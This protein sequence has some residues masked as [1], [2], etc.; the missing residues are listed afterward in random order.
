MNDSQKNTNLRINRVLAADVGST[1]PLAARQM[2]NEPRDADDEDD[3][4]HRPK[5]VVGMKIG[6]N[7]CKLYSTKN[8]RKIKGANSQ[9]SRST[10]R[11]AYMLE[12]KSVGDDPGIAADEGRG[13][14]S[15]LGGDGWGRGGA[16]SGDAGVGVGTGVG[17]DEEERL[18][19]EETEAAEEEELKTGKD[20]DE[21]V[22][23]EEVA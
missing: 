1:S 15:G 16:G 12:T 20:T 11:L 22:E 8:G 13:E 17:T 4:E 18:E 14:E 19:G 7:I 21:R 2:P 3:E 5:T 6:K 23:I 9:I 10:I